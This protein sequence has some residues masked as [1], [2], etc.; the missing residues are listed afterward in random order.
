MPQQNRGLTPHGIARVSTLSELAAVL[1]QLRRRQAR[2]RG[3]AELT[4][5]ELTVQTGW[6]LGI[7]SQYFAGRTL[8]P[9]DRFDTLVRLL[10]ATPAEQGALATARD[11]VEEA[12][13]HPE[14]AAV[15]EQP[16]P[17]QLPPDVFGFTGRT[18]QL[19]T[20]NR[21]LDTA[22]PTTVVISALSG[23]AGVGKTALA[24]HWAHQ[25]AGRFPDG[26]L[27]VNLRGFDPGGTPTGP[28]E[29]V[30]GFLDALGTPPQ[31]IPVS[32]DAQVGLYRS[33]LAGRR[34]LVLLDNARDA[35]QVRPLLPGAPGCLVVVTS[36][37]R[38][39]GL[40][41]TDGAQPVDLT[42]LTPAESR[43]LLINRLGQDRVTQES[44]AVDEI[45][46]ACA[47]LP[48]ALAIVATRAASN[49]SLTMAALAGQ[50]RDA[51]DR[52]APFS[53]DDPATDVR[54]VFFWSY[55]VLGAAAARLFRLIG[56]HPGP[57]LS[58]PAAASMVG[59][60]VEH[61][62]RLLAELSRANLASE[63]RPGRYSCHDLLRA[64]AAELPGDQPQRRQAAAQRLLEHYLHTARTADRLL[65]AHRDPF[66]LPPAL[67]GVV[68]EELADHLAALS[69]FTAEHGVLLA[70]IRWAAAIGFDAHAWRLAWT[71]TTYLDRQGH[72]HDQA[73]VQ[74]AALAAARKLSDLDG[75]ARIHRNLGAAYAKL[76]RLPTAK[77]HLRQ[78]LGLYRAAGDRTGQAHTHL[79]LGFVV[80]RQGRAYDALDHARQALE[81][82]QATGHRYGQANAL[83]NVGWYHGLM[84]N[85]GEALLSCRR[86]LALHEELGNVSGQAATWDS[87]G[88]AQHHLGRHQEAVSSF[89]RALELTRD[90][91]DLYH[92]A[93]TLT[94]LGDT[95]RAA[96]DPGA[97]RQ[98][99]QESLAILHELGHP[100]VEQVKSKLDE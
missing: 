65:Y 62:R 99:W 33:L 9:T 58:A 53:T 46:A 55:R 39:A 88:H 17:R 28:A 34:I 3:E 73:E 35:E 8:A 5:R 60:P 75:Q 20:L 77:G 13:R 70:A 94:H 32:L 18:R 91:G 63:H 37:N 6:S 59:V 43:Q 40:T 22:G 74:G 1:R 7:L 14:S 64:Y 83:N 11:R 87:L 10:G 86:A 47:R 25:I 51:R 80:H 82:F 98:V 4:Y 79:N 16:L 27:Y 42:L 54:G 92:Q 61:A 69:W 23:T 49:P 29:A 95:H 93:A 67:P 30:R 31:R 84:G 12:R 90:L 15:S 45:V 76:G 48:L 81:L 97:A 72:W 21:L 50:L 41:V 85:H 56:L 36:R 96:G 19:A 68:P 44:Q 2:Q 26:Q 52:L 38:L 24:V 100:D 89:R 78:A 71:M 57:D 66:T